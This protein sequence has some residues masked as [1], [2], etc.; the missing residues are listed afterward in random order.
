MHTLITTQKDGL[1]IDQAEQLANFFNRVT[2]ESA[3]S[4]ARAAALFLLAHIKEEMLAEEMYESLA[5]LYK[6]EKLHDVNLSL[7]TIQV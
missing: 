6:M 7:E 4:S 2:D 1:S 5:D 3:P